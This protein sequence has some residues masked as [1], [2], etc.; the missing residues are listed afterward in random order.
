MIWSDVATTPSLVWFEL[1]GYNIPITYA[2]ISGSN[3]FAATTSKTTTDL[4]LLSVK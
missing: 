1:A 2:Q 4:V 3:A